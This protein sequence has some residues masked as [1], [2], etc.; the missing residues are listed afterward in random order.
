MVF[1]AVNL[2]DAGQEYVYTSSFK[3]KRVHVKAKQ[4]T[5][6]WSPQWSTVVIWTNIKAFFL[7]FFLTCSMSGHL[8]W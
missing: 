4:Q 1:V 7:F 3:G 6:L 8:H 5:E 2:P